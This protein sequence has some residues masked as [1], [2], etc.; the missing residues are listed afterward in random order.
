MTDYCEYELALIVA[1]GKVATDDDLGIGWMD[2]VEVLICDL[3]ATVTTAGEMD[4][5]GTEW[6]HYCE[7]CWEAVAAERVAYEENQ[8]TGTCEWCKN[9]ATDRREFRS[10]DDQPWE[11]SLVCGSCRSKDHS[12]AEVELEA[13]YR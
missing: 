8:R 10:Y 7:G 4:S 1:T 11:T 12:R 3:P 13:Y 9:K 2:K 5:F 6:Q